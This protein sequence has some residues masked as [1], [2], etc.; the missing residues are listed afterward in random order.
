MTDN[1]TAAFDETITDRIIGSV[2]EMTDHAFSKDFERR[3]EKLIKQGESAPAKRKISVRRITAIITAAVVAAAAAAVSSGALKNLFGKFTMDKQTTH[4]ALHSSD[5]IDTPQY[6][7]KVYLPD[8]PFGMKLVSSGPYI[9]EEP[10]H[11]SSYEGGGKYLSVVQYTK[12]SFSSNVDTEGTKLEYISLNGC[13]GLMTEKGS[14]Y[15]ITID[16][17]EYIF[18]LCGT[19]SRDEMIKA[20]DSLCK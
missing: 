7:E 15:L 9:K 18:Q 4:T 10:M 8:V 16:S 17:G 2:P 3:M 19:L 11:Y 14:D 6:I 1:I 13:S 12:S 5:A 20:A